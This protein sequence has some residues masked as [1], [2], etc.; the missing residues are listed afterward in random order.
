MNRICL[1]CGLLWGIVLT[2]CAVRAEDVGFVPLFNGRDLTG[3]QVIGGREDSWQVL[4]G[5]I[6]ATTGEGGGW[7][8][9][10]KEYANFELK[11]EF[12]VPPD[13]NSGVFI[14][15]PHE[16]LPHVEGMEIQVLDDYAEIHKNLRPYQYCGSLYG[17]VAASP[18]VSKPAGEWQSLHIICRGNVVQVI[19]NDTLVVDANLN[20]HADKAKEHPGI[21]RTKGYIGLQNHGTRVE[22]RN[23]RIKLED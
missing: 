3:W 5:E 20:D 11:L 4:E 16:G 23:V 15:A 8:S 10:E 6:L 21:T 13:G 9:T 2:M 19:L 1:P 12:R 17:V 14:R 22:Y 18:R 7:L